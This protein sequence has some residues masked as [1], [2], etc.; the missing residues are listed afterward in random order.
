MDFIRKAVVAVVAVL[1]L[2]GVAQAKPK[3]PSIEMLAA[4]PVMSSFAVSPDGKHIAAL[5]GRGEDRVI[6]VWR[7][8][9][10]S[11]PPTVIGTKTMKFLSVSMPKNGVLAVT[12]WQP[13]DLKFDTT[14]K[15]FVNKLFLTDLEGKNWR[16]PL[17]LP[18]PKSET[19][20]LEQSLSSP[21]VLD[22]LPNDPDHILVVNNVGVEAGDIHK[23][24]V[25]TGRAERVQRAE[26]GT[27]SYITDLDG[28]LRA[29][30][31]LD[32]TASG[33]AY[34]ATEIRDAGSSAWTEHY[35]SYAKSRDIY[36]IVGFSKNPNI[37]YVASNVGRDKVAIYEYD[38]AARKLGSIA[39]EHK[40]FDATGITV[41]KSKG[42]SFGDIARFEY[43]GPFGD[44]RYLVSPKAL[45]MDQLLS[46]ALGIVETPQVL[47]D[48]ATGDRATVKMRMGRNFRGVG[49]VGGSDAENDSA[50]IVRVFAPNEPS[51]YY[52]FRDKKELVLLA[53]SYPELDSA[54]LGDSK[55]VYYKARDGLDIPA[56]LHTPN[57]ELCGP[58]PWPTVIH[59]HGG[60]WARDDMQFD[61]SMWVPI[62]V[63]RC[64]AVLQPQYRGS[65]D[66]WGRKLWMAGDAEWGQKMQDDKDD[67]AKWLIDQKIA[68]PGRIAMFGFSYGGYAAFAASVRPNGL[69]KCAIAGA[70]V[71]DIKLIWARF[72]RNF[73]FRDAQESTV[74]GLN[75]LE[76]ADKI[77]IPIYV[78][79]GDRDQ[80]VPIRQ[81]EL[82]VNKAKA[83][84]RDV[85]YK[86]FKDYAHGP[87]WTRAT[88]ADQLRGIDDYLTKG[89]GGGGL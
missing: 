64:R 13:Y 19:E 89:C 2:A 22:T 54:A 41:V 62:L 40:F 32:I 35:R 20:E 69:Y 46:Q 86:E 50:V 21:E 37:A 39:F 71:S 77:Q 48:P 11:S 82:F 9:A 83:A 59:P 51:S 16:E 30:S 58:G 65:A 55:L 5:E 1:A 24:N 60:P 87:S 33:G 7:S 67:G 4:Y 76:Y 42:E 53:R 56:Y 14:T 78:Y 29:R 17:A 73:Y 52:L 72:Y 3:V 79:H 49:A 31:R 28:T 15:T 63:S 45:E 44:E 36:S 34:I 43:A 8:D 18:R 81:S 70:G 25:R 80:I 74:R 88:M 66:G 23:V 26:E 84:G 27:F 47:V 6:L 10:L 38:I 12:V 57:T 75:P 85:K 61:G 68:A